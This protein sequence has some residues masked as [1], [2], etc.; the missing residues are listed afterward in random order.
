M[1][2]L[3]LP[4][5]VYFTSI[6][7]LVLSLL[8]AS[9]CVGI[10]TGLFAQPV[11][12][13]ASKLGLQISGGDVAELSSEYFLANFG[14]DTDENESSA[15]LSKSNNLWEGVQNGEVGVQGGMRF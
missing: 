3:H 11:G 15:L 1:S 7:L 8:L 10:H 2:K 13:N 4:C 12:A 5:T 6:S 14:F 9:G